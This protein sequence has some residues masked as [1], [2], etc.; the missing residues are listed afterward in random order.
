MSIA[1]LVL[2]A[3]VGAHIKRFSDVWNA[4]SNT[5]DWL[6]SFLPEDTNSPRP[7]VVP[8]AH[9]MRNLEPRT[10][11]LTLPPKETWATTHWLDPDEELL[12]VEYELARLRPYH[13]LVDPCHDAGNC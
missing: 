6:H 3:P 10:S 4:D 9:M 1:T 11:M 2:P 12:L 5:A 8:G 7:D 13:E